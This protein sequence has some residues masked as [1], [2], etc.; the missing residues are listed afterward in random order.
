MYSP[1]IQQNNMLDQKIAVDYM[2]NENKD[3]SQLCR[4]KNRNW[5]TGVLK[6]ICRDE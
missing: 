1:N 4:M 2:C 5:Y 3:N 6:H